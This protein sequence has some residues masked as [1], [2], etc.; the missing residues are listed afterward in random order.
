M[1]RLWIWFYAVLAIL[2]LSSAAM[3]PY[4]LSSF[5]PNLSPVLHYGPSLILIA[6][7][8]C[9]VWSLFGN[10]HA[11]RFSAMA[12]PIW[13]IYMLCA[14]LYLPALEQFRPVKSFCRIIE[15]Q[16]GGDDEAGVFGTALPSM[17][18]Y[19]RR[20]IFEENSP[21]QM[22]ERF[23]SEKQIFCILNRK[24]FGYFAGRQDLN[25]HILDR[26]SN[27]AVRFGALLNAG[28][29]PGEELLLVSNRPFSKVKSG[30]SGPAS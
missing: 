22:L 12:I 9:Q 6:G 26:H 25:I 15:A 20:P 8:A 23:R 11:Q 19:L 24:D 10:S 4:V 1:N 14:V 13:V 3:L 7:F 16:S 18:Y 28:Y 2:L 5:L 17:V 27:F 21:E 29:F 30:G